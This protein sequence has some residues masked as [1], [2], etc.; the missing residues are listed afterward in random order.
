MWLTLRRVCNYQDWSWKAVP[1][2]CHLL[3]C[4]EEYALLPL[5]EYLDETT[6]NSKEKKNLIKKVD[7]WLFIIQFLTLISLE[8]QIRTLLTFCLIYL[9]WIRN[10]FT[11]WNTISW[12]F[13]KLFLL[14]YFFIFV[15]LTT[16][17]S[18]Y[19]SH[20]QIVV[21]YYYLCMFFNI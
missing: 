2:N 17:N 19:G 15:Q 16:R 20:Y 5:H 9:T 7:I 18:F 12:T 3:L 21:T 6:W 1:K 10:T 11:G 4:S 14:T 13:V 8:V